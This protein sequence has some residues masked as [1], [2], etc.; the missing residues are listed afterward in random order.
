MPKEIIQTNIGVEQEVIVPY[1]KDT[2]RLILQFNDYDSSW[3]LNVVN[4]DTKAQI[5]NGLTLVVGNDVFFGTGLKYGSLTLIDSDPSNTNPIN[6]KKDFGD[7]LKLV[8]N[9]DA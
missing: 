1:G 3:F 7:R 8:R 2:L 9:F 5:I 4:E 6:P